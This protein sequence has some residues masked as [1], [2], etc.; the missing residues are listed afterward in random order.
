LRELFRNYLAFRAYVEANEVPDIL[1]APDGQTWS[2]WDIE[3]LIERVPHLPARQAQAIQ[4]CV[5][6]GHREKDAA[7]MMGVSPTNPVGCYATSG[8]ENVI[9]WI[10]YHGSSSE[11][12]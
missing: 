11:G 3:Y 6:E 8:L 1:T 5:L 4:L 9:A 10:A 2:L 12:R 7:V